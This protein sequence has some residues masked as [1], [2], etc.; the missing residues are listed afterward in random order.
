MREAFVPPITYK[1]EPRPE[2]IND[3][4]A[5]LMAHAS[6]LPA[7]AVAALLMITLQKLVRRAPCRARGE[8]GGQE[9]EGKLEHCDKRFQHFLS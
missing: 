3:T 7:A 6:Q 9:R 1:K 2:V 4:W 8:A 5:L